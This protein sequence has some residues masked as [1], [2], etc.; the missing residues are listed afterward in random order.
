[1]FQLDQIEEDG[2]VYD[3]H[4]RYNDGKRFTVEEFLNFLLENRRNRFGNVTFTSEP[5][6][7][8]NVIYE[9]KYGKTQSIIDEEIAK[10]E[11]ISGTSIGGCRLMNY[12]LVIGN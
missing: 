7:K 6:E 4:F 10:K 8:N 11:I 9:Y 2:C 1:M 12:D 5:R 3:I